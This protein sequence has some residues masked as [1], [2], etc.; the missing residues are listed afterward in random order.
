MLNHLIQSTVFAVV[1]GVLTLFLRDNHA[2]TRYWIW[3]TASLKF[4]APF[5]LFVEI[6]HRL[7]WSAAPVITRPQLVFVVD[8]ISQPFTAPSSAVIPALDSGTKSIV[9]EL[10]LS[11]WIIGC[12]AVLVFWFVRWRRVAAVMRAGKSLREGREIRAL[13][14]M[15]SGIEL[16][17]S[18]S[19]IEPGV[20][21][22][23]RPVLSLPAGIGDH[24]DDSQLDAI[25]AHEL[26][27]VRRRDNLTATLHMLVEAA[28]W[29]H[30]LVWWIGARLVE[31][32]ERACDED[33]VLLGCSPES[34]AEGILKIC[35]LYLE[36]P[37]V[38][39]SGV[40]GSDLRK[41]IEG[42]MGDRALFRLNFAKK[43]ALAAVGLVA[44]AIP[45]AIG[46]LNAP[47]LR[48]QAKS[49]TPKFD[50][51]SIRP[52]CLGGEAV[53]MKTGGGRQTK[54]GRGNAEISSAGRLAVCR[55]LADL[56]HMAYVMYAGGHFHGVWGPQFESGPPLE[57]GPAWVR[58][59]HYQVIARAEGAPGREV[60]SG[61]MLQSLLEDR[62]QLKLHRDTR[63]VPV[64]AL[65]AASGVVKLK[66]PAANCVSVQPQQPG[67]PV[68]PLQ[69]GQ[70]YCMALIGF[71]KGPNTGLNAEATTLDHFVELLSHLVDRP[72]VNK[73]GI[74]GKF[75]IYLE[76]AVDE[77]TPRFLPGGDMAQTQ[78]MSSNDPAGASVFTAIQQL[79]LKL[80]PAKGPGEF[81]VIDHVE[82]PSGN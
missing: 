17:S 53:A 10:L 66:P 41:R 34:Y 19:Q 21:G 75:D 4:L 77:A 16:I 80:E 65:T 8:T 31:E 54:S 14:R 63:E 72:V 27:H 62:F 52:G 61:P 70:K 44:L 48:A 2:R 23:L 50:A 7:S 13:R 69:P 81:L 78:A 40:T 58:S 30:P 33:V 35:K 68:V 6:G 57:G 51:A 39:V 49:S 37:L 79:G 9:P 56:I 18:P 20:F 15:G 55:S 3:L 45:V 12:A 29:F 36:S 73:T 71:R 24:L 28:F 64:Y 11:I 43:A 38:C 46:I 74:P 32:R 76:F 67:D 82:R 47:N 1:A 26:S 59:D 5:S 22:I 60:V 25:L 42:I